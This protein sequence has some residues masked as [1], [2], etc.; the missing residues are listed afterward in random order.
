MYKLMEIK[1]VITGRND[2]WVK[3]EIKKEIKIFI[4][5]NENTTQ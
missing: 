1:Q 3:E 2:E 5:Q 4:L